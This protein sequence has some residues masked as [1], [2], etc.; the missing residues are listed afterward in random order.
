MPGS[1]C[2]PYALFGGRTSANSCWYSAISSPDT[3]HAVTLAPRN[4]A[5]LP[6]FQRWRALAE[7]LGL[8]TLFDICGDGETAFLDALAASDRVI[9]TSVAEGFGMV[10]LE[11]WLAGKPLSGRDLPGITVEF[12]S[13]GMR[14]P[15][16]RKAFDVPL[17]WI[18]DRDRLADAFDRAYAWACEQYG[19]RPDPTERE[20]ARQL[21]GDDRRTIDFALLPGKFQELVIRH[22]AADP[23]VAQTELEALNPGLAGIQADDRCEQSV[24]DANAAIVRSTYCLPKVG[25]RLDRI[26]RSVA[27]STSGD[28]RP[29]TAG[30]AILAYFLKA[31]RLHAIRFEE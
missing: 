15:G 3:W 7:E 18:P 6:S 23:A 12:E 17:A 19:V 21:A 11:T 29:L 10:F 27:R 1:F 14:F 16:L 22:A 24:I 20:H 8:R 13:A 25:R 2:I 4:P 5:E 30:D 28:L 26:Y 31:D 9:T